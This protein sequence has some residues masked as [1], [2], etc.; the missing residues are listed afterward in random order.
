MKSNHAGYEKLRKISRHV[1][2][3]SGISQLLGWDQ[4]TYMPADAGAAR[5]EQLE[6]LAGIIH[7]EQTSKKF[8][9]ALS[10]LIDIDS[11]HIKDATLSPAQKAALREWRR[12]YH[13]ATALPNKFVEEFCKLASQS[14]LVWRK[15]KQDDSFQQ[16][17]PYLDKIIQMNRKKADYLGFKDHPYDALL[18]LYEPNVTTAEITTLFSSLKHSITDLLKTIQSKKQV[19][20]S[21][22]F[23]SFDSDKQIA[24][25]QDLLDGIGYN[26]NRGRLDFSAHPFSSSSHP[27]DSR[28]TT[29]IHPT[30]LMSNLSAVLHE[31]GHAFYEMG[32]PV[33]EFGTP[34]GESISLG[35]HE[36][37]SRWWET[38]IGHSKPFWTYYFPKLQQAF[39]SQLKH[40]SLGQFYKALNQVQPGFIRIEA[41]EI[42]YSLHVILRFE[43]EKALIEGSLKVRDIPEAWNEKMQQLLGITPPTIAQ[44]CLQDIHWSMGAFGYFPTYTLGN[45]YA[46][47]F[48]EAFEKQHPQWDKQVEGGDVQFIRNW[49]HENIHQH[50][51]RYTGKELLE[52]TTGKALDASAYTKYLK[53]KYSEIYNN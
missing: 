36:S 39:H 50:G 12:D 47:H 40:I 1:K 20:A 26:K 34:L 6:T 33:E 51:R 38:R 16:F 28:I 14:Q 18:D 13:H 24:F 52:K 35:I 4:E 25:S 9:N 23:G 41:D 27:T 48:F 2:V 21:F 19:D 53:H 10:E 15:A 45:L 5:G 7:K 37:Q 11:G 43:M 22:L 17:A 30:S 32:L 46:A 29:R 42:T 8:G 31:A 49:L 44:G 3:L